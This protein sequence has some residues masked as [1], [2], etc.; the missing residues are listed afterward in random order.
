MPL[1]PPL[2]IGEVMVSDSR[3]GKKRG[4]DGENGGW[5]FQ[6][7]FRAVNL[8]VAECST[9]QN[10]KM[11]WVPAQ[12]NAGVAARGNLATGV[13][14]RSNSAAASTSTRKHSTATLNGEASGKF[15]YYP[16]AG[17]ENGLLERLPS[18]TI[19]MRYSRNDVVRFRIS[20]NT[21]R[22]F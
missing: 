12:R 4:G 1:F 10:H 20:A 16:S 5:R 19:S 13:A 15:S 2:F 22:I 9:A 17:G 14:T 8:L 11:R 7:V 21:D 6:L 18:L 3:G